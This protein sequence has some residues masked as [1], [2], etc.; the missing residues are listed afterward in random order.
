[1]RGEVLRNV[2][3][4][5]VAASASGDKRGAEQAHRQAAGH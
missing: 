3:R 1:V 4:Q 5:S 2:G